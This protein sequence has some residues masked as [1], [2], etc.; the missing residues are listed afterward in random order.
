LEELNFEELAFEEL[1]FEELAFEE[2]AFEELAFEELTFEELT[3]EEL[4][5]KELAFEE[6]AFEELAFEELAF[7]KLAYEELAYEELAFKE[8]AFEELAFEELAFEELA[9]DFRGT[10][11]F[12]ELASKELAKNASFRENVTL[13]LDRFQTQTVKEVVDVNLI[14]IEVSVTTTASIEAVRS[15]FELLMVVDLHEILWGKCIVVLSSYNKSNF[16]IF[17]NFFLKNNY[18]W[19]GGR[20][21]GREGGRVENCHSNYLG[22]CCKVARLQGC[23]VA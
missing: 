18:C 9:I 15:S 14:I 3:F 20:E 22:D 23:K 4:A 21:G 6:L 1:A 5:F 19:R 7:E 12:K 8:L 13:C 17:L 16:E 2:L 10:L 11:T